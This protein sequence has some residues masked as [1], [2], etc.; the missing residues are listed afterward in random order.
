MHTCV[1]KY[2]PMHLYNSQMSPNSFSTHWVFRALYTAAAEVEEESA[3]TSS[4]VFT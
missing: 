1:Y 3:H 2:T 4:I